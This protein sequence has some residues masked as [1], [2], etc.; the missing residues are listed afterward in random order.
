MSCQPI[1]VVDKVSVAAMPPFFEEWSRLLRY[2]TLAL[3]HY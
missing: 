3:S 2:I 1:G